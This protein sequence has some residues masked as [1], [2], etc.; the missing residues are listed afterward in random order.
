MTCFTLADRITWLRSDKGPLGPLSHDKF[1]AH[2]KE[3]GAPEKTNRQTIISWERGGEPR[4]QAAAALARFSGFPVEAFS[5]HGAELL[6]KKTALSRLG[7]VEAWIERILQALGDQ[8]IE[9]PGERAGPQSA[10]VEPRSQT[11][12]GRKKGRGR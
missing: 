10:P 3:V 4:E 5:R 2:L 6:V 12:E 1:A 9:I 11:A 7:Q 8:G